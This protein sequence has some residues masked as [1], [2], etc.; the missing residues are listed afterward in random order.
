[1]KA[2]RQWKIKSSVKSME[3]GLVV[4]EIPRMNLN[5]K[6]SETLNLMRRNAP[7]ANFVVCKH[8]D[9]QVILRVGRDI[10]PYSVGVGR[11]VRK[12]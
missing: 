4:D 7:N 5:S 1:M 10:V 8:N 2:S 11:K 12:Q 3:P 9:S 6:T